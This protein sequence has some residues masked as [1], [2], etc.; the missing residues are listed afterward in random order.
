[1]AGFRGLISGATGNRAYA[2]VAG[3]DLEN[4]PQGPVPFT[5]PMGLPVTRMVTWHAGGTQPG[6]ASGGVPGIAVQRVAGNPNV[7][8][9]SSQVQRL[10]YGGVVDTASTI[11]RGVPPGPG[12]GPIGGDE[13]GDPNTT[14]AGGQSQFGWPRPLNSG[15]ETATPRQGPV[16]AENDKL[17]TYDRHAIFK[18]GYENSGRSSGETD[19]P[20]DG[21]ARPSLWLVQRTINAQ[22]GSDNSL[23]QDDLSRDYTRATMNPAS[24]RPAWLNQPNY[25]GAVSGYMGREG[26]LFAGEQ[27]AGWSPVYGGVPGLWQPYGSYAG[28]TNG[29]VQGIQSPV[30]LGA[31]GD[32]TRKIW[33]GPPHGLHS[34]TLP[35]Y[36][37]TIGRYMAITQM[38]LP[39]QDRP[40]NSPIAGQSYSQTVQPQGQT[41]TVVA[42]TGPSGPNWNARSRGNGWRGRA[43]GG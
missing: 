29:P 19:P 6:A 11:N 36:S 17:T 26:E 14:W 15:Q 4:P 24:A 39:R 13:G 31:A 41:G 42:G 34:P 5:S 9:T 21:P 20:M 30:P 2:G 12:P 10:P 1:M 43:A 37:Q 7:A 32:G 16:G 40:S 38:S 3:A 8:T 27:G 25:R 22:Q 18:V 33:G 23:T 35:T 28:I